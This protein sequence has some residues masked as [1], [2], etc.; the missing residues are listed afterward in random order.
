MKTKGLYTVKSWWEYQ[1][2]LVTETDAVKL[3]YDFEVRAGPLIRAQQPDIVII[4]KRTQL[5]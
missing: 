1:P 2:E 4:D 3:L 5:Q